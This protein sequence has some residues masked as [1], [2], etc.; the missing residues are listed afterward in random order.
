MERLYHAALVNDGGRPCY[1]IALLEKVSENPQ[2][3]RGLLRSWQGSYPDASVPSWEVF[4]R[5]LSRWEDFRVWQLVN[6]GIYN[7]DRDYL[8][9]VEKEK[10]MATTERE[11][12]ELAALATNPSHL[13][14][15]WKD[16]QDQRRQDYPHLWRM[17]E[18]K[19]AGAEKGVAEKPAAPDGDDDYFRAYVERVKRR[20]ALHGFMRTFKLEEDPKRQDKLTTWIEY[21]NYEYAWYDR[22]IRAVTRLQ[23]QHDEDWTKL[24]DSGVL[25][26]SETERHLLTEESAFECQREWSAAYNARQFA[27][28]TAEALLVESEKAKHGRSRLSTSERKRRLARAHSRM[29]AANE[30]W[31]A[32]KRRA[33]LIDGFVDGIKDYRIAKDDV[34]RQEILLQWIL[35]QIPLIE[36]EL[37]ESPVAKLESELGV[38]DPPAS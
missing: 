10:R 6:R 27:R 14:P 12:E 16:K 19:P 34:Y 11:M 7:A 13:R 23:P 38:A 8:A 33:D 28:K 22:Y 17:E 36:A 15:L 2:A 37:N 26:P 9:F 1:P 25:Q 31:E 24:V 5:Q 20:L 32:T 29:V 4:D 3:Y 18:P 30:S 21:L 35:E